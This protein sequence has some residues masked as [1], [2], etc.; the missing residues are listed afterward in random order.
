MCGVA[1]LAAAL[2]APAGAERGAFA[3]GM[4][5]ALIALLAP[6][7]LATARSWRNDLVLAAAAG[8]ASFLALAGF[9]VKAPGFGAAIGV[10]TLLGAW[11]ALIAGAFRAGSRFGPAG[12]HLVASGLGLALCATHLLADPVV[13][14]VEKQPGLRKFVIATTLQVNP[15]LVL[16][17]AFWDRDLLK[18]AYGYARSE[19]G[20][21]H[22]YTYA[23]WGWVALAYVACGVAFRLAGP[24]GEAAAEGEAA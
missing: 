13:S 5:P 17:A 19:I 22:G 7:G 18:T 9:L 15:S 1:V 23:G 10:G 20:S 6:F 12:G 21:F 16:S 3:T 4:A 2:A 11:T 8:A 24:R 14:A